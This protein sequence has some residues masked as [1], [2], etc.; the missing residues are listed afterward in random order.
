MLFI[1]HTHISVSESVIRGNFFVYKTLSFIFLPICRS[2]RCI[3]ENM[4][5]RFSILWFN[6]DLNSACR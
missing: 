3:S 2:V 1:I 5:L 4:M 6:Y